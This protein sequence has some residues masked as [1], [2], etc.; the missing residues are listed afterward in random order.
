MTWID[1][2]EYCL[3]I[4]KKGDLSFPWDEKLHSFK[5]NQEKIQILDNIRKNAKTNPSVDLNDL[6]SSIFSQCQLQEIKKSND[7]LDLKMTW[8]QVKE[9]NE[10]ENFIIGGHSHTHR[11]LAFL[12]EKELDIEI[13]TSINL[14]E[15]KSG[16][17]VCHYSYPEGLHYCYSDE[18]I[19]VL[20]NNG[21][22]CCPTAEE[23]INKIPG[24]LFHLKRKMVA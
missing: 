9:L 6:V 15:Q 16:I 8:E 13:K 11:N 24:S 3:E 2:I 18:V 4:T 7:P 17:N 19:K 12:N 22:I 23:G 10:N 1:R 21:I 20:K 5:N 14:I